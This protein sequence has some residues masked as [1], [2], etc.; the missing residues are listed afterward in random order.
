MIFGLIRNLIGG[1]TPIG[2]PP[3]NPEIGAFGMA[4]SSAFDVV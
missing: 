4:F 3:P 2:P 1:S